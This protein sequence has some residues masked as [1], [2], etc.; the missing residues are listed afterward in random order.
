MKLTRF[1]MVPVMLAAIALTGPMLD[2][3]EAKQA[4]VALDGNCAVC[5]VK[6]KK[7]VKG[8]PRHA[9][10]FDGRT[11]LFPSEEVKKSF[12]ASPE[13]YVPALNGDCTICFA[14]HDG[15]RNPGKIEHVSFYQ[16]RAFLFPNDSL[17]AMFE[18]SP[19]KY[20]DVDLAHGGKCAV[21][22]IDGGKEIAGKPEFTA[23]F[24]GLR[25]QFPNQS[26]LQK[27]QANPA[28]YTGQKK[29]GLKTSANTATETK[30]VSVKGTTGCAAC[31]YGVH[32]KQD[33]DELGLA[34][35]SNDGFIYVVEGAHDSHPDLY[36]SRFQSLKVSVMGKEI[37][38]KGK[39]VWL[40]PKSIETVQ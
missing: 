27:F 9:V 26:V 31:E 15:V 8:S 5:L 40:Q 38:R 33:P 30:L 2:A 1:L 6:S 37:A 13:K 22:K 4:P 7:I 39:I 36:K 3:K 29:E 21:C 16:G 18:Q 19:Q 23:I 14:H 12:A 24:Q 20:A 10:V 34:V 35:K 25:Y 28:K 11:Y 17:K 32:P